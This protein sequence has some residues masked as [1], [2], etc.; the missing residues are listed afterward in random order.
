MTLKTVEEGA[1]K[2]RK[3]WVRNRENGG[4]RQDRELSSG[5]QIYIEPEKKNYS[6]W[7]LEEFQRTITPLGPRVIEVSHQGDLALVP[8]KD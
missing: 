6:T 2:S 1:G 5:L 8:V 7:S 3:Y 4:N